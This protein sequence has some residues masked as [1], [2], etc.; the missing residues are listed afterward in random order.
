MHVN[1]KCQ[2]AR[3]SLLGALVSS[4][5]CFDFR[6]ETSSIEDRVEAS[7]SALGKVM[8]VEASGSALGH[9]MVDASASA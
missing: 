5:I 2:L 7:G 6:N 8:V 3:V 4:D 9:E 1:L